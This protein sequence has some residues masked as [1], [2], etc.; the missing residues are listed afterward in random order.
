MSTEQIQ[1][2]LASGPCT[3]TKTLE[4][5]MLERAKE[6]QPTESIRDNKRRRRMRAI[7]EKLAQFSKSSNG[8]KVLLLAIWITSVATGI[9]F[10]LPFF[11]TLGELF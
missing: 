10:P 3:C 11:E 7:R 8:Y 9:T 5:G 2:D 4:D 1:N 6:L